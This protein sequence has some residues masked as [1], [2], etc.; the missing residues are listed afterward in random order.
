MGGH[1]NTCL[2]PG[3]FN[4]FSV[5]ANAA[6][7]NKRVLFA[8]DDEGRVFGRQLLALTDDGGLLAFHCYAHSQRVGF[9]DIAKEFATKLAEDMGTLVVATGRVS[10]LVAPRWYDDGPIDFASEHAA[11]K[12]GSRFRH[13]LKTVKARH[14]LQATSDALAPLPLNELTLPRILALPELSGRPELVVLFLPLA[15]QTALSLTAVVAFVEVLLKAG[16]LNTDF[17]AR[18][19]HEAALREVNVH[20]HWTFTAVE[21]LVRIAPARALDVLRRTRDKDVRRWADDWDGWRLRLVALAHEGLH[22][23][24]K[25]LEFWQLAMDANGSAPFRREYQDA[26]ERLQGPD[27]A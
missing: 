24:N 10:T 18:W 16:D 14:V 8:R 6:D 13:S 4:Y 21:L 22:R 26:M 1:F 23:R 3:A 11:L 25:A 7:I 20:D 19:V 2:A 9:L 5:I 27:G 17:A 15:K 12:E